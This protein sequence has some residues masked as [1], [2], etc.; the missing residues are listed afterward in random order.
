MRSIILNR[1]HC[2]DFLLWKNISYKVSPT[3][4]YCNTDCRTTLLKDQSI[5]VMSSTKDLISGI[6]L[7]LVAVLTEGPFQ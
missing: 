4:H 7:C 2:T 6:V 3:L 5:Q 1:F